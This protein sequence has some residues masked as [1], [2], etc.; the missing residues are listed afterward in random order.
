[1]QVKLFVGL[2]FHEDNSFA[3]KIQSYRGRFDEKSVKMP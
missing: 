1:M 3:K 2:T